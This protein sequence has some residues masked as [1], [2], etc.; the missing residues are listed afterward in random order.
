M[1]ALL[2]KIVNAYIAA[3]QAN[4]VFVAGLTI[5]GG[6]CIACAICAMTD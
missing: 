5:I 1:I 2:E 4:P 3:L 6:I